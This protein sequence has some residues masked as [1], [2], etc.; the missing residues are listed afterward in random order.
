MADTRRPHQDL[1]GKEIHILG[2]PLTGAFFDIMVSFYQQKLVDYGAISEDLAERAT[3]AAG[4]RLDSRGMVED[5]TK[6]YEEAP[7]SF[8]DALAEARDEL[9]VRLALTW[10]AL[11]PAHLTFAKVART[12]LTIDRRLTGARYQ[13]PIID[14]FRW[15]Q[16]GFQVSVRGLSKSSD[17]RETH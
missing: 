10:Q 6:A 5:F 1:T 17:K 12:F 9:G 8:R 15:R 4:G 7:Y 2:Q 16:I 3:R 11:S 14:C 13:D